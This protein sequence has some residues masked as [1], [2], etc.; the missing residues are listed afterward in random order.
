MNRQEQAVAYHRAG[1]NCAQAILLA[2]CEE[3]GLQKEFASKVSAGFGG[4]MRV[5]GTCGIV[6]GGLMVLGLKYGQVEAADQ[7]TKMRAGK[8]AVD[9]Q[10]RFKALYQTTYCK[11]LLGHNISTP[12]G[13][14]AIKEKGL[15]EVKC[16]PM[17]KEVVEILENM[18][19][20]NNLN[21]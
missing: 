3:L 6:T 1:F 13:M 20:E 16:N 9:F 5:G 19:D 10:N 7:E 15:S 11:E 12:E 14:A 4:G 2:F 21:I 18:L 8:I 17:I